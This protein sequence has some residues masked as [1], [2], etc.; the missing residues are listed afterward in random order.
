M[1]SSSASASAKTVTA[2]LPL[3]RSLGLALVLGM[4]ASFTAHLHA[5]LATGPSSAS[6]AGSPVLDRLQADLEAQRRALQDL[7]AR[8]RAQVE[9]RK[10]AVDLLEKQV[11]SLQADLDARR[12][13]DE[14]ATAEER[15]RLSAASDAVS[16]AQGRVEQERQ[17]LVAAAAERSRLAEQA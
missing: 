5:K 13:A 11:R 6:E 2:R 12:Q 17:R 10:A 15:A 9:A 7:Q 3:L 14:R 1:R 8:T 16:A 4:A